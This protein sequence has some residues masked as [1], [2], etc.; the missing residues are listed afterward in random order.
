MFVLWDGAFLLA[1]TIDPTEIDTSIYRMYVDTVVKG[2]KDLQCTIT[3]KI[4]L[5]LEHV[6]WQM[7]NIEG[8]L[9][10]KL[11]DWVERLHQ[12]GKR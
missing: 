10:D 12:T 1:R 9:G 7:T 5:M 11:D 4:H 2:G 8:G 3:S 6:E